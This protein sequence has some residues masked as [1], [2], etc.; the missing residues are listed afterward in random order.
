MRRI[1]LAIAMLLCSAPALAQTDPVMIDDLTTVEVQAAIDAGKTTAVY[2]VGGT[3]QNGPAVVLG[4][5][6]LLAR[7]I[8]ERVA[9]GLGN[10]LAYP[11]NP[12][13]PAG[14]PIEKTG[15]MRFAGTV[16][17]SNDTLRAVSRD[18]AISALAVGFTHVAILG[19][20]GG[21]Q[22]LLREVAS[23]LDADIAAVAS[24]PSLG[25]VPVS[26]TGRSRGAMREVSATSMVGPA[27]RM[28]PIDDASE[29]LAVA[30]DRVRRERLDADIAAVASVDLGRRFIDGKVEV[31]IASIREQ[32][33]R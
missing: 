21:G 6:N 29:I 22:D 31:A 1:T 26:S 19:D 25:Y 30:S 2:Y 4:K 5:H 18:V 12:Y 33:G 27:N 9:R 10:A 28:T 8:S 3:H 20:H 17:V 13:A 11:P 24:R 32:V 16:S 7:H 14:D 15:H 23:E